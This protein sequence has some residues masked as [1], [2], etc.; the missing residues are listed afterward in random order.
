MTTTR[1]VCVIGEHGVGIPKLGVVLHDISQ[2]FH[3]KFGQPDET[4]VTDDQGEFSFS[5]V[6]Y[7]LPGAAGDHL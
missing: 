1:V 2:H 6:G 5:Y 3:V 4:R 7:P